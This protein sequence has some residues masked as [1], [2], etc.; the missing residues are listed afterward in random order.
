MLKNHASIKV[1]QTL[2]MIEETNIDIYGAPELIYLSLSK[3]DFDK[4]Y[5]HGD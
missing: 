2:G 5:N 4:T 3:T 1:L